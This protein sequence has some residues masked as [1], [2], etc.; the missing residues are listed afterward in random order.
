MF[1]GHTTTQLRQEI[2]NLMCHEPTI[3]QQNSKDRILFMSMYNDMGWTARNTA[4]LS[5]K[6]S[7]KVPDHATKFSEGYWTFFGLGNDNKWYGTLTYKLHREWNR[8]SGAYD[9]E[10]CRKP[11]APRNKS[12]G[13]RIFEK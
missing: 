11:R 2:Q 1:P 5:F 12:F 13:Q 3:E 6:N 7:S 9:V 10:L 4:S 8:N